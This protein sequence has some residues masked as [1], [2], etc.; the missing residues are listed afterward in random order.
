MVAHD[1][2]T[3]LF[4][5][6]VTVHDSACIYAVRHDFFC[7]PLLSTMLLLEPFTYEIVHFFQQ[8][9]T[10]YLHAHAHARA[11]HARTHAHWL[12][13]KKRVRRLL[14]YTILLMGSCNELEKLTDKKMVF[15]CQLCACS[16]LDDALD[17]KLQNR[18][19]RGKISFF[20]WKSVCLSTLYSDAPACLTIASRSKGRLW[21]RISL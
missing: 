5:T 12:T 1:R 2:W 13:Y 9:K 11:T 15:S 4:N 18:K 20:L 7:I 17:G 10:F 3:L 8:A 6:V 19:K 16:F 14:R 21:P